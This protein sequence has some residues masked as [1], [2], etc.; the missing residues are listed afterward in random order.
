MGENAKHD[1]L[2][3]LPFE[4]HVEEAIGEEAG[5]EKVKPKVKPKSIQK[6]TGWNSF[7]QLVAVSIYD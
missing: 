3:N 7:Y 2:P 4:Q 5:A 6:P 1:I